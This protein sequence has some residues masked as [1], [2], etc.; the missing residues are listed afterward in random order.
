MVVVVY[1]ACLCCVMFVIDVLYVCVA[2]VWCVA[3]VL[4]CVCLC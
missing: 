3:V 2:I 1:R 4:S